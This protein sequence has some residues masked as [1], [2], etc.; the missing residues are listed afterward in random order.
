MVPK[1]VEAYRSG[2][3]VAIRGDRPNRP[4]WLTTGATKLQGKKTRDSG[5]QRI[6]EDLLLTTWWAEDAQVPYG[7]PGR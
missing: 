4:S 5:P 3:K 1:F 2:G 7:R 6:S